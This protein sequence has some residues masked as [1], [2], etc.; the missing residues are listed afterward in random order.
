MMKNLLRTL[1]PLALLGMLSLPALAVDVHLTLKPEQ[2]LNRIDEKI[3]SHFLEHI[4]SSINGGLWGELV[5]NR[6]FEDHSGGRWSQTDGIISQRA[7]GEDH[8]LLF[9]DADWSDYEFTVEAQKTAGAEGFLLLFR[10]QNDDVFSWA[11]LGGW[12]NQQHAIERRGAGQGRQSV[13]G[14]QVN[15]TIETGKWYKITVRCEGN[16]VKVSIDGT[17]VLDIADPGMARAGRVGIGTWSTQAQFR[18]F[19]VTS[20]DGQTVLFDEVPPV[21]NA[22][23]LRHW[24]TF[25][26]NFG[27]ISLNTTD[28]LNG[29]T[30][31]Q[32]EPRERQPI[33]IKQAGYNL[34]QGETYMVSFW[35][36]QIRG[37]ADG[38]AIHLRFS[39]GPESQERGGFHILEKRATNEWAR[40]TAEFTPPRDMPDGILELLALGTNAAVLIDQISI[41][42]KSWAENGGFRPDLLQAIADLRPP[43]IRYPGGCFA[44]AYRWKDGI[45]PQDKRGPYPFSIWDDLEVNSFGTDEFIAMCRAVGAEPMIVINIGTPMWNVDRTP[46]TADVDWLQEALDW[47]EYCN[48]CPETTKW[49]RIRAENG[50]PEPYNVKYWEIDN[51]IETS[52]EDYVAALKKFIPAMKAMDPTIKIAACGSW[53]GTLDERRRFDRGVIEGAAELF[54]WLSFHHYEWD[55][56]NFATGPLWLESYFHEIK[57][58]IDDSA[59]PNI[60]IF[61]SEW[62]AQSTDWRTGLYA[63]GLL[64]V[65]E[66]CGDF[67]EMAAPALFLRHARATAW[68]NAF[69]NFD[70]RTWYPA[71]NYVVMKLWRNHYAPIRIGLD[72]DMQ[73]LNVVATKSEDGKT[74]Y[75]KAVNPTNEVRNVT[76]NVGADMQESSLKLVTARGLNDRNTLANPT[77]ITPR[78]V[79]V[80]VEGGAVRFT[81]PAYSAGVLVVE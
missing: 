41:M 35:A 36:K 2:E 7:G 30:S 4:Y 29:N 16:N 34:K 51:E 72:G 27:T 68:D 54:D 31:V 38:V 65:F 22:V 59:N 74:L 10:V 50:H 67:M 52:I 20:L 66:R 70:N 49:G 76:L 24:E 17:Q 11:N 33:G 1:L 71:P 62:N 18:N 63:G 44:S 55:A 21:S 32:I 26:D 73:G 78:D 47:L 48:G 61:D 69:I 81:L 53:R 40:F 15:G 25:G 9:G 60:K 57:A 58:M 46:E 77:A 56:D 6:S 28:A 8:R 13:V 45:G 3:Y 79:E 19:R 75:F 43:V 5:W 39:F 12:N 64:N 23:R 42:P 14:R 37:T 80:K